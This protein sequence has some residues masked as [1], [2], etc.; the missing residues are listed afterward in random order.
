MADQRT[1]AIIKPDAVARNL[2][3][4]IISRIEKVGLVVA[5]ARMTRLSAADASGFY[6]EHRGKPFY[7]GLI[8]FMTSGP[9]LVMVLEGENA[10]ERYRALMG[11]T[12]SPDGP[13]GCIRRDFGK[14]NRRNAV[15]GSD[16]PA[17]ALRET[18]F[19]FKPEEIY[20]RAAPRV[21]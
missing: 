1:L 4:E 11:P 12:N 7:D 16:G 2:S 14:D 5:A 8:E 20:P 13:A 6:A 18:T 21:P 3:G 10:V 9:I 19:F 17:S 15:H